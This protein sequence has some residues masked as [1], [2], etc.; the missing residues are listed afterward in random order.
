MKTT[1]RISLSIL[2]SLVTVGQ[3]GLL[4]Y[5]QGQP[6]TQT[7]NITG[8]EGGGYSITATVKPQK[9]DV[10]AMPLSIIPTAIPKT[11]TGDP[12]QAGKKLPPDDQ[13]ANQQ[14]G[15]QKPGE[16]QTA[17]QQ[18]G[19]QQPV[20][21]QQIEEINKKI[22]EQLQKQQQE[23]T[24][25]LQKQQ[26]ELV[27]Q[28]TQQQQQSAQQLAQ[29]QQQA[30][31][32]LAQ[33]QQQANQQLANQQRQAN[34]QLANQQAQ[35]AQQ[36][37]AGLNN[38]AQAQAQQAQALA[39]QA[40]LARAQMARQQQALGRLFAQARRDQMNRDFERAML[41]NPMLQNQLGQGGMNGV[42]GLVQQL[43]QAA[44]QM[45]NRQGQGQGQGQ[46]QPA[47]AQQPSL[48]E[49]AAKLQQMLG[50]K[51]SE[52]A[53]QKVLETL[54]QST[55]APSAMAMKEDMSRFASLM[56]P[57]AA[58]SKDADDMNFGPDDYEKL[59]ELADK[60]GRGDKQITKQF[61]EM[62]LDATGRVASGDSY[63]QDDKKKAREFALKLVTRFRELKDQV[64]S[65]S[66]SERS[67]RSVLEFDIDKC[68]R[69]NN[70][71]A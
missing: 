62:S 39:Q 28:L 14:P 33:Q 11:A 1:R 51:L 70:E 53:A 56:K 31:Q 19:Q 15:E 17:Q 68:M 36:I 42:L 41:G 30:N 3:T 9:Q 47:V 38:L 69:I 7:F 27:K 63:S 64:G 45:G 5:A 10:Q 59:A 12:D 52:D 43:I 67:M 49:L 13:T 44:S 8:K 24:Q 34:Q 48:D 22:A 35:N 20:T 26:E 55:A 40:Q 4:A 18:P 6:Y 71:M 46:Q 54:K 66:A 37:N 50:Q 32:Q 2:V 60:L 23:L 21:A 65:G 58:A 16:Q 25:Q 57:E 29:Q 61:L